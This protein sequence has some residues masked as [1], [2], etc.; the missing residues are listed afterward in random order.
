MATLNHLSV[1]GHLD[2]F[3]FGAALT[4]AAVNIQMQVSVKIAIFIYT[5]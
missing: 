1:D 3:Q 4:E 2:S 5:E